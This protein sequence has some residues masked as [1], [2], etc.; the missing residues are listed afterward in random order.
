MAGA[1]DLFRLVAGWRHAG[2]VPLQTRGY[3]RRC[4]I[5]LAKPCRTWRTSLVVRCCYRPF[6][7]DRFLPLHRAS[8]TVF[9]AWPGGLN[10]VDHLHARGCVAE[11][12]AVPASDTACGMGMVAWCGLWHGLAGG[13]RFRREPDCPCFPIGRDRRPRA[14][15]R[16]PE[17]CR[18]NHAAAVAVQSLWH[19][20][21]R[22][23]C[24]RHQQGRGLQHG[25][26]MGAA[27]AA[28]LLAVFHSVHCRFVWPDK[29]AQ[30]RK[31]DGI[32]LVS[33]LWRACGALFTRH[34]RVCTGCPA[35]VRLCSCQPFDRARTSG[36]AGVHRSAAGRRA[37]CP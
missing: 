9:P 33:G 30:S 24:S 4:G 36:S 20:D 3:R 10:G 14:V 7:A 1:T 19:S 15:A 2:L 5:V 26:G 8:R 35:V 31:T 21:L 11:A 28:R 6:G 22:H 34:R 18:R 29:A 32:S 16:L 12:L 27:R 17:S 13:C 25:S 23:I 37:L